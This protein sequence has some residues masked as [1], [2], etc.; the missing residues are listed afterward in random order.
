M[1]HSTGTPTKD[2]AMRMDY[3]K[4]ASICMCC[5]QLKPHP[6]LIMPY[7]VEVHHLLKG[8]KRMGH[9][10]TVGLCVW[11]HRGIPMYGKSRRQMIEIY[12]HSLADGSKPFR[13]QFGSDE[14]LL[15]MQDNLF[16]EGYEILDAD[17]SGD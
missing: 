7:A 2:E 14:D 6:D 3:I 5:R 9:R 13:A 16:W 4:T 17:A 8:N 11:H 10:F 1:K 12:G 15:A